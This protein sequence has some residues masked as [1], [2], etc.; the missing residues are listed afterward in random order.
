MITV[1]G[2]K[3]SSNVKKVLWCLTELGLTLSAERCG[4]AVRWSRYPGIPRHERIKLF[5]PIRTVNLFSGESNA[6]LSY[7]ADKYDDSTAAA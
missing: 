5:R 4:R 6:I 2:R 7:L 3:N 1:W